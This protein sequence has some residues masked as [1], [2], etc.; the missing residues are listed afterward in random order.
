MLLTPFFSLLT[1]AFPLV[2]DFS[3]VVLVM[4]LHLFE[5]H[6]LLLVLPLLVTYFLFQE[7]VGL[8]HVLF[9]FLF[10]ALEVLDCFYLVSIFK[11]VF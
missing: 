1:S 11:P 6:I 4:L 7:H 8:V 10:L 9:D 3:K 2:S 5:R